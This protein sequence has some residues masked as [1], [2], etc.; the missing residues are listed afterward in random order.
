MSDCGA[1]VLSSSLKRAIVMTSIMS[2]NND[3]THGDGDDAE[4]TWMEDELEDTADRADSP[5]DGADGALPSAAEVSIA[6]DE[7]VASALHTTIERFR[8]RRSA[9]DLE[10]A[11]SAPKKR[12]KASAPR[13]SRDEKLLRASV[14][15]VHI[16]AVAEVIRQWSRVADRSLLQATLASMLPTDIAHNVIPTA[17]PKTN[18]QT[19]P[20]SPATMI[21]RLP[22]VDVLSARHLL[23]WF[24]SVIRLDTQS[25][26]ELLAVRCSGGSWKAYHRCAQ[27]QVN[28]AITQGSAAGMILVIIFIAM[29]RGAGM[30]CRLVYAVS[31]TKPTQTSRTDSLSQRRRASDVILRHR[32][33]QTRLPC[34]CLQIRRTNS[35]SKTP[36]ASLVHLLDDDDDDDDDF[37]IAD[38]GR[39]VQPERKVDAPIDGCQ[40]CGGNESSK[41]N[42][43]LLCDECD[44]EYHV[45]CVSLSKV[46]KGEWRCR[47][48]K[49]TQP[50]RSETLNRVSP[51][52]SVDASSVCAVIPSVWCEVYSASEVRWLHIDVINGI[53][54]SPKIYEEKLKAVWAYVVAAAPS[55]SQLIHD[56][57]DNRTFVHDVT[58]RYASKWSATERHRTDERRWMETLEQLNPLETRFDRILHRQEE[59]TFRRAVAAEPV[60]TSLSA[61][62]SHKRYIAD[63]HVL[64]FECIYPSDPSR[65]VAT[66]QAKG[67]TVHVYPRSMLQQLHTKDRWMREHCRRVKE[68]E[69][70]RPAKLVKQHTMHSAHKRNAKMK[71][72]GEEYAHLVDDDES[73][74]MSQLY[75]FWQTDEWRPPPCVDGKIPKNERGN[76][77]FFKPE[78]QLP[79]GAQHL[80]YPRIAAVARSMG[81][82]Y[83]EAMTGFDVRRGG[84]IPK[85]DGIIVCGRVRAFYSVC[86]FRT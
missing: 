39:S 16:V 65:A 9:A 67:Q 37:I 24:R 17:E 22:H 41:K 6:L 82:D 48:C 14:R 61:L 47:R 64:K 18:T 85:F 35:Q 58:K 78:L 62:K 77:D 44:G 46:P 60:P 53:V 63:C 73:Q 32:M 49:P 81:I 2:V 11:D 51:V 15:A 30:L 12:Q 38:D 74:A 31:A 29:C 34:A 80:G 3:D 54:D 4:T 66:I 86:V 25:A 42:P 70:S 50:L 71:R 57:D 13:L 84:M 5:T 36:S 79:H 28:A 83:A 21:R 52:K 56:R 8:R 26:A 68:S 10:S 45:R 19:A 59:R 23:D 20:L 40:S 69:L 27:R 75:G 55:T 7:V 1:H 76:I 43:I 72:Y 33:E